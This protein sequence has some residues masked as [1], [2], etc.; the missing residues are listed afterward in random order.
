MKKRILIVGASHFGE[1]AAHHI[2][3]DSLCEVIGFI[4]D[5][6]PSKKPLGIYNVLGGIEDIESLFLEGRF[7]FLFLAIG[8]RHLDMKAELYNRFKGK[9]PFFTFI[10]PSCTIDSTCTIEEGCFIF[11]GSILDMNV[12]VGAN[13]ILNVGCIVAHDT[14]IGAH[15]FLGPAVSL[16]GF[17]KCEERVHFGI[18][19]TIIDNLTI[20]SGTK[21]G[22]GAVVVKSITTPGLY[23][24][25][26]AK[27]IK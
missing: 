1:Q 23:I 22:A 21:T 6:N 13:T 20:C 17:T 25:V 10:H 16:A 11:S 7:N 14:E 15:S 4:D 26:P 2:V 3:K 24:G 12:K 18:N 19:S 27:K 9:I 8:Y 5:F